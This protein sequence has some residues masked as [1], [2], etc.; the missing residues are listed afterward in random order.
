M[1]RSRLADAMLKGVNAPDVIESVIHY[2]DSSYNSG[3]C[4]ACA[5]GA[6]LIGKYGGDYRK[7]EEAY[8]KWPGDSDTKL[9][10]LLDIPIALAIEVE[11]LH[12]SGKSIK[13]IA[14]WLKSSEQQ[15]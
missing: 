9:A 13:E 12:L 8:D 14:A 15:E 4:M 11:W 2:I 7:A 10:R 3:P 5:L 6:A 1:N